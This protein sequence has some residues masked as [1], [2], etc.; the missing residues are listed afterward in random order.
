M[1]TINS[2]YVVCDIRHFEAHYYITTSLKDAVAYINEHPR[3]F[4]YAKRLGKLGICRIDKFCNIK[5]C[6]EIVDGKA[7]AI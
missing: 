7:V 5:K 1:E 3:G 6:W 4:D 2:F